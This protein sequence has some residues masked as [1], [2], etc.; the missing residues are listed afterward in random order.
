VTREAIN[1][2][3]QTISVLAIFRDH[4]SDLETSHEAAPILIPDT[5]HASRT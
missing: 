2:I 1:S 5:D 3:G 4:P